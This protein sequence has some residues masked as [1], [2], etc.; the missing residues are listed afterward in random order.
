MIASADLVVTKEGDTITVRR[1]LLS[2]AADGTTTPVGLAGKTV[3]IRC[4][5]ALTGTVIKNDA[6]ATIDDGNLGYVS[7]TFSASELSRVG[8]HRITW[9]VS[10]GAGDPMSYPIEGFDLLLVEEKL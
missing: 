3:K 10:Q 6:L 9:K 7:A 5:H 2:L 4:V 8:S 1:A